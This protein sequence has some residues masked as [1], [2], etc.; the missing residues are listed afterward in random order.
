MFLCRGRLGDQARLWGQRIVN[1]S[2]LGG[3]QLVGNAQLGVSRLKTTQDPFRDPFH[4]Y[5]HRFSVFVPACVGRSEAMR[6]GLRRL[7]AAEAPAHAVA[8]LVYVEPRMRIGTQSMIG[9]DAVIGC[10]PGS[11]VTLGSCASN[12]GSRLGRATVLGATRRGGPTLRIGGNAR[13]GTTTR[14]H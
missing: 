4:Y 12:E 13:V 14:L 3:Q 10:Y 1:R 9:Y 8:H 5:A 7:I 11:S 2:Q 6:N